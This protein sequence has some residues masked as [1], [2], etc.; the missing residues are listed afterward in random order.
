MDINAAFPSKYLKAADLN[1]AAVTV[2][3]ER[4]AIEELGAK[5]QPK[6]Q[7]LVIYFK[8]KEKGMVLNKTNAFEVARIANSSDT[9]DW[10]GVV[11]RLLAREVEYQGK[12]TMGLRVG[13]VPRTPVKKATPPP[14]PVEDASIEQDEVPF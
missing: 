4:V 6:E 3:I 2:T 5:D 7:K 12:V 11:I 10:D 13:P 1:G 14:P 8:G 9:E